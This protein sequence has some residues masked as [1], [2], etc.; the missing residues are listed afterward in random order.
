MG[1]DQALFLWHHCLL[2]GPIRGLQSAPG[3]FKVNL[4]K[5]Q[6]LNVCFVIFGN[7]LPFKLHTGWADFGDPHNGPSSDRSLLK[8]VKVT[9]YGAEEPQDRARISGAKGL[10]HLFHELERLKCYSW[11][12]SGVEIIKTLQSF[13]GGFADSIVLV[14]E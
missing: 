4:R 11:R 9:L 5:L 13:A 6:H 14:T 10:M 12:T 3:C 8:R 1:Q 7:L 2:D